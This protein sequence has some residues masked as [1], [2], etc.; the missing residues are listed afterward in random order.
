MAGNKK[1]WDGVLNPGGI[2]GGLVCGLVAGAIVLAYADPNNSG[3]RVFRLPILAAIGG[4][5]A[6]TVVWG[7]CFSKPDPLVVAVTA[8]HTQIV[9]RGAECPRCNLHHTDYR[10]TTPGKSLDDTCIICRSCGR[11]SAASE[12]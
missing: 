12:F 1:K 5:Y 10:L 4:A 11:S 6:G 7:K 3:R 2:I 8:A 9:E